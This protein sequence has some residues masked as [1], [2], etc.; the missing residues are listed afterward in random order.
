MMLRD[1]GATR[2]R[3]TTG[4]CVLVPAMRSNPCKI[5]NLL[6]FFSH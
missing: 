5:A 6:D 4:F 2:G 3:G 1:E